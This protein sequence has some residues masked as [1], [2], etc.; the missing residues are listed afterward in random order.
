[1]IKDKLSQCVQRSC[2]LV[3]IGNTLRSD[4][5][6]GPL[7]IKLLRGKTF[8]PL[9]D[10]GS[11][12]ENVL[13]PISKLAPEEIILLDA[14]S[15]EGPVGSLHWV[16][17]SELDDIGISTHSPSLNLFVSFIKEYNAKAQIHLIGVVP[18]R[19]DFAGE[20]TDK[21]RHAACELAEIFS[22]MCPPDQAANSIGTPDG[23]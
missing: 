15:L 8:L 17:P 14:L 2:L 19:L 9:I 22:S 18:E 7:I 5:G 10:A 20:M 11:A 23:Q 6:F 13:G 4:D 3:G 1:M 21:V 16:E 12:P